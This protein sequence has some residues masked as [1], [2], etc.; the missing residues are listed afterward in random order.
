MS[1]AIIRPT[2]YAYQEGVT[3]PE[4]AY[5]NDTS[6]KITTADKNYP[7][8]VFTDFDMSEIPDNISKINNIRIC[9]YGRP[10]SVSSM[11][12]R[13]VYNADSNGGYTDCGDGSVE[14]P[15]KSGL[16][17]YKV[18]MPQAVNYWNNNLSDFINGGFQM[19]FY[20]IDD[21]DAVYEAYAEIDYDSPVV[22]TS[23]VYCGTKKVSVYCGTKKLSTYCGTKLI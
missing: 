20:Y 6:T 13:A 3:S 15:W 17:D 2:G 7:R 23:N 4:K 12:V 9:V 5:D 11:S 1:T 18:S 10:A 21:A 14:M 19:R 22:D 16:N 8:I